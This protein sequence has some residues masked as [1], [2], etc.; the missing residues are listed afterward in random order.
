M[1]VSKTVFGEDLMLNPIAYC[2]YKDEF[3]AKRRERQHRE[4]IEEPQGWEIFGE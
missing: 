2:E 1:I 3:D 4:Q